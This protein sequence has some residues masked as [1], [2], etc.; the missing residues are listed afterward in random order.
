MADK[1]LAAAAEAGQTPG[2]QP[3]AVWLAQGM[4]IMV[5]GGAARR[6]VG[7]WPSAAAEPLPSAGGWRALAV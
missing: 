1:Q 7:E 5:E 3:D 4:G 6:L 2:V